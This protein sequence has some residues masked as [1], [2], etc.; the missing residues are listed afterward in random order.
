MDLSIEVSFAIASNSPRELAGFYGNLNHAEIFQ[1]LNNNHW[2]I[3]IRDS[4]KIE[5]YRPSKD[6]LC[7]KEGNSCAL[8][9]KQQ[10][11]D[12]PL[13]I[14]TDWTNYLCELG[15]KV[16]TQARVEFFGAEIWVA[17]P[18]DNEF[19]LVVTNMDR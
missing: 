10:A 3:L 2:F 12:E 1:G 15:G 9:F 18:E 17:D 16:I 8:C 13:K 5:F 14:L 4:S 6:L 19:L 7:P 11:T